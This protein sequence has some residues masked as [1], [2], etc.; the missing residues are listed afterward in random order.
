MTHSYDDEVQFRTKQTVSSHLAEIE[1]EIA[2]NER[3]LENLILSEEDR[4]QTA[5]FIA[6]LRQERQRLLVVLNG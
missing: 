3:R 1:K 6:D 2:W 4:L 5:D